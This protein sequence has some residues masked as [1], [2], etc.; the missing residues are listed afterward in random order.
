MQ[1][2]KKK[3]KRSEKTSLLHALPNLQLDNKL[4]ALKL[5]VLQPDLDGAA[6]S[7]GIDGL[8]ETIVIAAGGPTVVEATDVAAG[9][10]LTEA[11]VVGVADLDEIRV[12]EEEVGTGEGGGAGAADEFHD[13]AARDV[14]VLVDVDG[15]LVVGE[16]ELGFR[17]A[18]HAERPLVLDA[19][20]DG[21]HVRGRRVGG[22]GEGEFFVQRQ[23]FD[24]PRRR[25]RQRR[26]K[27]VQA[28]GVGRDVEVVEVAEE[29]GRAASGE[30][31]G[32]ARAAFGGLLIHGF[33]DLK[34]P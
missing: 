9:D 25:H 15:A 29:F 33:E 27:Q 21:G 31:R 23:H 12:E 2:T 18:E 28:E 26:V 14:A 13:D 8:D 30:G 7:L 3:R 6:A 11:A 34:T 20:R 19:R 22:D 24:A 17:E 32:E 16:E 1:S 10:D 5:R 4:H